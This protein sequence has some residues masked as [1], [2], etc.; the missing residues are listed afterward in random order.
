M[1]DVRKQLMIG[2]KSAVDGLSTGL[3]FYTKIPKGISYPYIYVAEI[4]DIEDGSKQQFMYQYE[5]TLE[6]TYKDIT[7]KTDMW[8]AVDSLKGLINNNEPFSL[9]D[10][11]KIMECTLIDT[12]E[13]EDLVES[14]NVDTTI[15]RI[16]FMIEDNN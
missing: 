4:F 3:T 7:D 5:V 10:N 11:F 13:I 14:Q 8:D 9:T 6:I 15:L 1:K 16:N 2:L 12:D